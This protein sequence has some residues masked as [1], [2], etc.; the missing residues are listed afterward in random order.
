MLMWSTPIKNKQM[1]R[2]YAP[3]KYKMYPM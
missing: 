1:L 3:V 2:K